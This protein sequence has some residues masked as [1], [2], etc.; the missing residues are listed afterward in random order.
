VTGDADT[1]VELLPPGDRSSIAR[2]GVSLGRRRGR[3]DPGGGWC[4]S[5]ISDAQRR[6]QG[7][8]KERR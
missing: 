4:T 3:G 6:R 2:E 5:A 1:L 8:H 7:Q